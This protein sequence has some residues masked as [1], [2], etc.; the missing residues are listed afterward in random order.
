MK[1]QPKKTK[2]IK[3]PSAKKSKKETQLGTPLSTPSQRLQSSCKNRE[4][5][6]ANKKKSQQLI[7]YD[8]NFNIED[9]NANSSGDETTYAD[10]NYVG[11]FHKLLEHDE[12][13]LLTEDAVAQFEEMQRRL[14]F[15]RDPD[16]SQTNGDLNGI[17]RANEMDQNPRIWVNP[18]SAFSFSLKGGDI[19]FF[20]MRPAPALNSAENAAEMIEVYLQTLCRDVAF[21]DYGTGLRT[22][23]F[24]LD[25]GNYISLTNFAAEVLNQFGEDFRG[26]KENGGVTPR[27]L[28]RGV[29]KVNSNTYS[30]LIGG[31]VSQLLL[32]PLYPLFPSGCAP[33]VGGKIGVNRLNQ[34]VLANPQHYP[35]AGEREFGVSLE[36]F[37]QI[38]NGFIPKQYEPRDY[39]QDYERH[40]I[41]GRDMGSLVHTDSPYEAY[42]N[43]L[44]ILL[45]NDFPR[46]RD[47]PYN[48]GNIL[49]EGDGHSMGP[50]D[51]YTLIAEVCLEA[52]K[53]SWAQKWRL[54][55]KLRP[56]AMAGIVNLSFNDATYQTDR[57]LH[58]SM[59]TDLSRQVLEM[60]KQ[61]NISQAECCRMLSKDA[62]SN[63]LLAQMYPEGSPAHPAY[64]SGHATVAGACTTVIKAIFDDT[65][66]FAAHLDRNNDRCQLSKVARPHPDMETALLSLEFKEDGYE[67]PNYREILNTMTVGSELDKLASNI[68]LGRNF[69]GVHYRQDGDEGILLGEKVAIAYLQD[70]LLSYTENRFTGYTL[71]RRNGDRINITS[72]SIDVIGHSGNNV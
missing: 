68:A 12:N 28:F 36:E 43:A 40:L 34:E 71:T 6:T 64:P 39:N 52:F 23:K 46:S 9:H 53:A 55:R 49:T 14:R 11:S 65:Q 61:R 48:N 38:Q 33:F 22:D 25:N 31:Y 13:G 47:F 8:V 58:P 32:Q 20:K 69:G 2:G 72:D 29:A 30:D 54:H 44:N 21:S 15:D 4:Q 35:I 18:Q 1:D 37:V 59:F 66:N 57:F 17:R 16:S 51:I 10:S 7:D 42:Y 24:R 5:S 41:N 67:I 50:S 27:T 26:L 60:I 70:H 56:E 45:Y 3:K 62:A 63:Y 19:S